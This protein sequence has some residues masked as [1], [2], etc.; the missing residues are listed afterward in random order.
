MWFQSMADYSWKSW[1]PLLVLEF[2]EMCMQLLIIADVCLKSIQLLNLACLPE[3]LACLVGC[4]EW[5]S[6]SRG[7]A[8]RDQDL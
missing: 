4:T 8:C 7:P 6:A 5:K 3:S 1:V 2:A